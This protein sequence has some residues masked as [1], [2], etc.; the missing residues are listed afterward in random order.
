MKSSTSAPTPNKTPS[1]GY[2]LKATV[3]LCPSL[4]R[5][6]WS[7]LRSDSE[8][9]SHSDSHSEPGP[10]S[11]SHSK[12]FATRPQLPLHIR[13][14]RSTHTPANP[15]PAEAMLY[16]LDNSGE[17]AFGPHGIPIGAYRRSRRLM[18]LPP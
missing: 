8:S 7:T 9:D 4:Q 6:K 15:D 2:R 14:E 11:H 13:R 10:D 17:N 5:Q 12:A 18:G 3:S 1:R 16:N